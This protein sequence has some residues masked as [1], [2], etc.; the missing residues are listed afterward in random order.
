MSKIFNI[1]GKC[2]AEKHYMADI[3]KKLER[4]FTMVERSDYFIINRPRQYGKT[5]ILFAIEERVMQEQDYIVFNITFEGL[6]EKSFE[7][8]ERFITFF[9]NLLI[10]NNVENQ[11]VPKKELNDAIAEVD[12]PTLNNI[13][14]SICKKINKKI[15]LIID[16][17]DK[18]TNNQLFLGFLGELRASYLNRERSHAFHS[19]ILAGVHDVKSLK[20]KLRPNEEE[21]LN[22][23]WNI[24]ADYTVNMNLQI[25]EIKPMLADYCQERGVA[26]NIDKMAEHLFYYTSGYPF[27]VSKLCKMLDEEVLPEK[28]KKEWTERDLEQTVQRLLKHDNTN[29][30]NVFKNLE[31]NPALYRMTEQILMNRSYYEFSYINPTVKL[32]ILHGI[33]KNCDGVK[34]HNVIY[35]ELIYEYMSSKARTALLL[36]TD[37]A[38]STYELPNKILDMERVLIEFQAFMKEQ[39][40]KKDRDF[41]EKHGRLV[42]LA[43][44]R[45]IL[46]GAGY[47]FKEVQISE[48]RR[49]DVVITYYDKK[50]IA[51]MKIWRGEKAHKEGIKQL[52]DYLNKNNQERGYLIVFDHSEVKEWTIKRIRSRGKKIYTV[53]V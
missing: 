36:D 28:E 18:S 1:T 51:E 20:L 47:D 42:F 50:Y 16:E 2:N 38:R 13:I 52:V 44:L 6:N 43:F 46:A 30:E 41:L 23:P 17:V 34:I 22:S 14:K 29:F 11:Y 49:L 9:T 39:Y 35:E 10:E 48:E 15:I 7:N 12:N 40:S 19:V 53:W 8:E 5:T 37:I 25:D 32:G 24:A 4:T 27:L 45:P 21:K 3:S 31:N 26:M 33:L